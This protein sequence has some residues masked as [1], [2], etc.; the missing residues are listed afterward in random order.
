MRVIVPI[1]M[2]VMAASACSAETP[3]P[4][5]TPVVE[6][7]PAEETPAEPP[8]KPIPQDASKG[9]SGIDTAMWFS[10][11]LQNGVKRLMYSARHSDEMA[12]NMQCRTPGLVTAL[13]VRNPGGAP[14]PPDAWPFTLM[15]GEETVDLE[16]KIAGA[17]GE[18]LYI[19]A[20]LPTAS[21]VLA[22]MAQTGNASLRDGERTVEMHAVGAE[23]RAAIADFVKACAG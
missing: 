13:I 20:E 11:T 5:P 8:E 10:D 16:G 4:V 3:A 14:K 12:I 19:E 9:P 7:P 22:A 21:P 17:D 18:A 6:Q 15:S 1:V 2:A 23:E